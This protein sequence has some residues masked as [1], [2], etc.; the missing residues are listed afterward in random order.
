MSGK[1]FSIGVTTVVYTLASNPLQR[2]VFTVTVTGGKTVAGGVL[3][4]DGVDDVV[5]LGNMSPISNGN[6]GQYSFEAWI[7]V[8]AYNTTEGIGGS[9]IFGDERNFNGGI[10]VQL[11]SAGY[12]ATFQPNVGPVT[13]TYKVPLDTWTHIAFVQNSSELDLY[14]NGNFV[15]TLLTAPNLHYDAYQVFVLGALTTDTTNYYWHFNGEM[16]EVRLW[17][18]AIC[19]AQIHAT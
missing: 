19:Q 6:Y 3:D 10:S 15:Q 8:R 1:Q 17:D 13:S 11:D 2:A 5:D 9:R 4:F 12:I 7:K 16:D 14:V 18:H